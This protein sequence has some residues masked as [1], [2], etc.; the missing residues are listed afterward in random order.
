MRRLVPVRYPIPASADH[1]VE[2]AAGG[3]E[4]GHVEL[5]AMIASMSASIAGSAMPARLFEP[6]SAAACEEKYERSELPGVEE[7]L[8]RSTVMSKSKPSAL[9][10]DT[11]R[12]RRHAATPRSRASPGS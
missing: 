11:A 1:A 2:G 8:N 3:D 9:V 7:K 12:D 10:R 4:G 6:L 5:A